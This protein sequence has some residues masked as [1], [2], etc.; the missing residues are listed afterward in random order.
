VTL[1]LSSQQYWYQSGVS[2]RFTVHAVDSKSQPCR[3]NIGTKSLSVVVAKGSRRIWSSA[4][5]ASGASSKSVVLSDGKPAVLRLTWDRKTSSPGC[6]GTQHLVLPGEYQVTAVAGHLHSKG[7][8]VVLGAK[9]A[10]GP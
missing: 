1:R 10:S 2:P 9:G 8:N 4:Y 5:C 6:K 3:F 7:V